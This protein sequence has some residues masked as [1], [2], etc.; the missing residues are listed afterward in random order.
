[1]L[2]TKKWREIVTCCGDPTEENFSICVSVFVFLFM[3]LVYLY[4]QLLVLIDITVITHVITVLL[5]NLRGN[6]DHG[7]FHI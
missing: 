1:M 2:K 4:S 6:T 3:A 7:D 5:L